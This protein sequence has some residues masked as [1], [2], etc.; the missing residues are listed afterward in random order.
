MLDHLETERLHIRPF[1]ADDLDAICEVWGDP[2][3]M[4]FVGEGVAFDRPAIAEGLRKRAE[5]ASDPLAPGT[6]A[7]ELKGT[8]V[9][10]SAG[11]SPLQEP[12]G[13]A[14]HEVAYHLA[15]AHWGRGLATEAARAWVEWGLGLAGLARVIGLTYAENV[16]S[17]RVLEKIGMR[18]MGTTDRYYST[19]LVHFERTQA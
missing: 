9:V 16:A 6:W 5:S 8:G 18:R 7:V 3:V 2:E 10:G 14:T 13:T 17:Q 11:L 4:R 19:S 12:D 15:R 1:R